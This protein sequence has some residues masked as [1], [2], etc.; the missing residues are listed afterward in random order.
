MTSQTVVHEE[1]LERIARAVLATLSAR[2][3]AQVLALKGDLGAG[4]TA[5]TKA[6]ARVLAIEESVTSPTF[7]IMKNYAIPGNARFDTLTHIDA[8]R[9]EEER[10]LEVLGFHELFQDEKRL[11]SIEWPER[12]PGLLPPHAFTLNINITADAERIITYAE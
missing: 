5:F 7:V 4:K 12:I 1:E 2:P 11:I 8:Y 9:I 10:E 3:G 6:L